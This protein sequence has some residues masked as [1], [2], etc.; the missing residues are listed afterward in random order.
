MLT[1]FHF[2]VTYTFKAE[3]TALRG[4]LRVCVCVCVWTVNTVMCCISTGNRCTFAPCFCSTSIMSLCARSAA[5][6]RGVMKL[7][8]EKQD[9]NWSRRE[10]RCWKTSGF[11][12]K[13]QSLTLCSFRW[14]WLLSVAAVQ[15]PVFFSGG[16][17]RRHSAESVTEVLKMSFCFIL[18]YWLLQTCRRFG[19]LFLWQFVHI[20]QLN[21]YPI[22]YYKKKEI[23]LTWRWAF[24]ME[25]SSFE[26]STQ[27]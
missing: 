25:F 17:R 7:L 21:S 16:A 2:W 14:R 9:N 8:R 10:I 20:L 27:S 23:I 13:A 19:E 18:S 4:G 15:Q 12:L 26:I 1:E 24:M 22:H 11:N 5:T 6:W 3:Y